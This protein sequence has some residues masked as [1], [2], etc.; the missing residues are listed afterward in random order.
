MGWRVWDQF[1]KDRRRA[2]WHG[3]RAASRAF[4][5]L[6][7][8]MVQMEIYA[9]AAQLSLLADAHVNSAQP[10]VNSGTISNLNVGG[11]Y[12]TY[13]LFDLSTLPANT[14]TSKISKATLR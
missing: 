7:F 1:S 12:N 13:L 8:L 11:G 3:R 5:V 9:D 14:T 4:A 2:S 6:L 10:D